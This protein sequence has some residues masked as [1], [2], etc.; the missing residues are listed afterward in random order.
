MERLAILGA[1][2]LGASLLAYIADRGDTRVVGFLDDVRKKGELAHGV[3]VIGNAGD[4]ASLR[5]ARAFDKLVYAIGYRDF[6]VRETV[7]DNLR[8]KGMPFYGVVH[9]TAYVHPSSKISEG[10]HLFPATVIDAAV[11]LDCNIVLNT[12]CIIAHHS[13]VR[14]HCYFG[15]GVR[16]AG[17]TEIGKCCFVGIGA[18][19]VEKIKIGEHCIIAAGAVVTDSA[20]PRSLMAGVPAVCKK[21]L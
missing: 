4:A 7:F 17:I 1:G 11:T 12:G 9:P 15:P 2:D 16:V 14:A 10:V 18:T 13:T 3:E 8:A 19:I 5:E 6:T 20:A 21:Q